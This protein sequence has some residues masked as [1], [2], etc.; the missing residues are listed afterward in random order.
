MFSL[1]TDQAEASLTWPHRRR[2]VASPPECS[3]CSRVMMSMLPEPQVGSQMLIP[4][5]G[6]RMRTISRIT[7]R[8][9]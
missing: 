4:G 6:A 5:V 3:T 2:F 7:S 9:V 8:G 1:Q